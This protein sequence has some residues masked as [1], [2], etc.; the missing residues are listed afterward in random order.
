MDA[1]VYLGTAR[2]PEDPT[3]E[4]LVTLWV[5]GQAEIA[6]RKRGSTIWGPPHPL[7]EQEVM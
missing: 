2:D 7:E 4:M 1:P 6:F 3:R 5:T